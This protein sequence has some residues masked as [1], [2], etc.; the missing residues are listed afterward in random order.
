M[1][2]SHE[3]KV[4]KVNVIIPF[5][6]QAYTL[7]V[8]AGLCHELILPITISTNHMSMRCTHYHFANINN[9][10]TLKRNYEIHFTMTAYFCIELI[11]W[12]GSMGRA[13]T[14]FQGK[15]RTS[16]AFVWCHNRSAGE[17]NILQSANLQITQQL[18][19]T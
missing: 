11:A 15:H 6:N 13:T 2:V 10:L 14:H 7:S 12:C 5:T 8:W 18:K 3:S 9:P 17:M 19:I 16:I 4:S 1:L